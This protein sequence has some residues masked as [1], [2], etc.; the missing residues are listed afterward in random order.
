MLTQFFG[1]GV[2]ITLVVGVICQVHAKFVVWTHIGVSTIHVGNVVAAVL[3]Y[4]DTFV[5]L[6][7]HILEWIYQL[8]VFG[9]P[10]LM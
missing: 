4:V 10:T 2:Y 5:G 1:C 7:K 9:N 8:C 3:L 6:M